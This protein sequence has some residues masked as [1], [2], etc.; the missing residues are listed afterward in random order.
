MSKLERCHD[1]LGA[2]IGAMEFLSVDLEELRDPQEY[3][4]NFKQLADLSEA[5]ETQA[6]W[7][8]EGPGSD[9]LPNET[10]KLEG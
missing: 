10:R 1:S 7:M 9:V 5:Y 8:I 4:R 6:R 2:A 3:K